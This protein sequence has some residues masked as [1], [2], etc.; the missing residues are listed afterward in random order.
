MFK[1]LQVGGILLYLCE[2]LILYELIVAGLAKKGC[3]YVVY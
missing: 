3:Y 1:P 2:L